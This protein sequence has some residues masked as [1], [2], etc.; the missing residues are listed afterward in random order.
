MGIPYPPI[1]CFASAPW[2]ARAPVDLHPEYGLLMHLD[3]SVADV[4]TLVVSQENSCRYCYA[5]VRAML[6]AQG[7]SEARIQRVEQD[8]SRADLA[9]R[10]VAAVAFGRSQSRTGP[11]GVRA[12]CDALRRPG[13][14][15]DEMREIAYAVADTDFSNRA[16]T[17]PAI[18][19]RTLERMPDQIHMRLLRPLIGRMLEKHRFRG[20]ATPPDGAPSAVY[21]SLIKACAGSP[22]GP[23]LARTN[24]GSDCRTA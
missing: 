8:L 4:T 7:M 10:L 17:I 1:R 9:P 3:Q 22:I 24:R 11:S 23:A 21:G 20:R 12:A 6:W 19:A 16:H 14:G 13:F 15:D 5:A 2:L 18:P